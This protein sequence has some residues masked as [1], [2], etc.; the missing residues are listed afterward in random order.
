MPRSQREVLSQS[1]LEH[2]ALKS[3]DPLAAGWVVLVS[4]VR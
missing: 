2:D 4:K 3:A 1:L